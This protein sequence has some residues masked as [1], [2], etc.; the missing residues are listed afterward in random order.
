MYNVEFLTCYMYMI[1]F[2]SLFSPVKCSVWNYPFK[3][4]WPHTGHFLFYFPIWNDLHKKSPCMTFFFFFSPLC[5]VKMK[6]MN[7][8]LQK[9][10]TSYMTFSFLFFS[11]EKE[12][13]EIIPSKLTDLSIRYYGISFLFFFSS[14][15]VD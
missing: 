10:L 15:N 11:S 5:S 12:E 3:I 2:F 7:L 8:F 13:D 6:N 14:G 9:N 4:T 1:F